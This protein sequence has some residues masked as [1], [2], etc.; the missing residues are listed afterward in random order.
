MKRTVYSFAGVIVL[1]TSPY[2]CHK[3]TSQ[4][5]YAHAKGCFAALDTNLNIV[6]PARF[7]QAGLDPDAIEMASSDDM[8]G[9]FDMGK[10][11]GMKPDAILKD[12]QRAKAAYVRSHTWQPPA[13]AG[14]KFIALGNQVNGCLADY[15]GRP[16]D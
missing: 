6:P 1:F 14:R 2:S 12:L 5:M 11:I 7:T 15:Y 9:A 8:S 16:N 13:G 3:P 10:E 4:E